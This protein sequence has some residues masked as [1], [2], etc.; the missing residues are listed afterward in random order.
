MKVARRPRCCASSLTPVRKVTAASALATPK[1]GAKVISSWPAPYSGFMVRTSTPTARMPCSTA[2]QKSWDLVAWRVAQMSTP[3][4]C[5]AH[6]SPETVRRMGSS[7]G[8]LLAV[9]SLSVASLSASSA[10]AAASSVAASSVA[11]VGS[12]AG[13][14]ASV[15]SSSEAESSKRPR[16]PCAA[17]AASILRQRKRGTTGFGSA[18]EGAAEVGAP[19][20]NPGM[21]EKSRRSCSHR[22]RRITVPG[23][24]AAAQGSTL[25]VPQ[26]GV[27]F[28]LGNPAAST[29]LGITLTDALGAT[30]RAPE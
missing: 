20:E 21:M 8:S 22:T 24:P 15:N 19:E 16:P 3:A 26:Y 18:A 27:S 30:P 25:S 28:Q 29:S 1:S 9:T 12:A 13:L 17:N 14:W 11:A 2:R 7:L 6:P 4:K 10:P 23:R 5:G